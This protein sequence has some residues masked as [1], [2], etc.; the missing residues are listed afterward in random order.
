MWGAR[1][2]RHWSVSI[3]T[4]P[5]P[6]TNVVSFTKRLLRPHPHPR[7]P[8]LTQIGRGYTDLLSAS[9]LQI[10]REVDGIF[11]AYPRKVTTA[12]LIPPIGPDEAAELTYYGSEV[13]HPFTMEQVVRCGI[14]IWIKN[15]E[16][17]GG[18]GGGGLQVCNTY[19]SFNRFRTNLWSGWTVLYIEGTATHTRHNSSDAASY[20]QH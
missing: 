9:E 17:R 3:L 13:V 14:P 7:L 18:G 20:I 8:P 19:T 11:T 1:S 10:W 15:V 4:L 6:R 2:H 12:R 16:R 5:T